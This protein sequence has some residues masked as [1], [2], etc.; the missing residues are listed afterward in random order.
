MQSI[1]TLIYKKGDATSLNNYRPIAMSNILGKVW[2]GYIASA[3]TLFTE[4]NHILSTAQEGFRKNK[5]CHRQL[6]ALINTI[7]DA[8]LHHKN[9][10]LLYI[11]LVTAFNTVNHQRL[12][13]V[14]LT[15]GRT[16][17]NLLTY[18]LGL[19]QDMSQHHF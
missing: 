17:C 19:P 9:L 4:R 15:L 7:E 13:E 6:R 1:T 14:L 11:D 12:H 10:Y 16:A 2:T 18:L 3:T 5:S 8:Q